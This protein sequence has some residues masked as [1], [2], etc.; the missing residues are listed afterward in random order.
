MRINTVDISGRGA[1]SAKK[2]LHW[3]KGKEGE[4]NEKGWRKRNPAID[5]PLTLCHA[6]AEM[7]D[8]DGCQEQPDDQQ[9][10]DGCGRKHHPP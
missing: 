3:P 8:E 2:I 4:E 1:G 6:S 5:D 7:G 10:Q 9:E